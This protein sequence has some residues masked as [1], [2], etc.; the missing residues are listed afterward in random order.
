MNMLWQFLQFPLSSLF[1]Q[2]VMILASFM[3]WDTAPSSQTEELVELAKDWSS[4]TQE[5]WLAITA[6]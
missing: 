2:I 6:F 1:F 3:S 5:Q 4:G